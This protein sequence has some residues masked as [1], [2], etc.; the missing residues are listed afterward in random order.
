MELDPLSIGI[1]IKDRRNELHLTQTDI[2]SKVGISSGNMSDI[3]RGNRF[4]TLG[5]FTC[6]FWYS[7]I[8]LQEEKLL[9]GLVLASN[10]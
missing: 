9:K 10:K 8:I 7:G 5:F 6:N 4:G 3:E 1:R 2:K